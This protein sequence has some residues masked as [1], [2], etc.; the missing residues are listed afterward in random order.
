MLRQAKDGTPVHPDR[1]DYRRAAWDAVHFPRLLDRFW[2]DLRRAVG[3]N[4]SALT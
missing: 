1:Y 4:V 3:W 2:Q